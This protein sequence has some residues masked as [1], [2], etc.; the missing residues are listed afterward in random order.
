M[1]APANGATISGT[2]TLSCNA[3]DNVGVT[4]VQFQLDGANI[5]SALTSAP[6]SFSL[7]T[8]SYS[9]GPHSLRAIARDA[10]GN[11]TT[12][13]AVTVT[14]SNSTGTGTLP[15]I[16]V[17]ASIPTA[18]LNSNYGAFTFTRT[19]STASALNVNY[20]LGGTA[21]KWN[22]YYRAGVGDMPT[23]ITIPSGSASYTMNIAARDNQTH[24]NPETVVLTLSSDPSYQVGTPNTATMTI[25]SNAPSGGPSGPSNITLQATRTLGGGMKFTWNSVVGKT[26]RVASKTDMTSPWVDLS[27]NIIA[28]NSTTSWTDTVMSHANRQFYTVYSIN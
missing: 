1:T 7:N 26:Y 5:G 28:T 19:G 4:S 6:Y 3:A 8:T 24:A 25:V 21:I 15:T 12:S 20:N 13:T 18:V 16:S 17:A 10:A 11:Q 14:I 2:A 9:N 22:D 23:T 27:G